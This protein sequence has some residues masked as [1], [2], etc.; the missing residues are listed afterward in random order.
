MIARSDQF[1]D[2]ADD[3]WYNIPN[4]PGDDLE[5][6][7][8]ILRE[9]M[10]MPE[11][12]PWMPEPTGGYEGPATAVCWG[13]GWDS[14][15]MLI[16]MWMM[17]WRPDVI[18]I[19]DTGGEKQG[20][21]DFIPIFIQW[22]IERDF[23]KPIICTYKPKEKTH[24]RYLKAT[25]NTVR[26]LGLKLSDERVERLARLYGNMVANDTL[27]GIAFGPKSCSIKWKVEAQ[28]FT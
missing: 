9:L 20:T 22:L 24:E 14:T 23:P 2:Y 15:A 12:E 1:R 6:V 3:D 17:G 13:G 19:A 25:Q 4:V 28:E 7:D 5:E 8:L 26:R 21:Y 10:A 27:P 16:R 11:P 18:T